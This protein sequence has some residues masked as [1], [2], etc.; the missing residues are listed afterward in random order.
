[1]C[2]NA[3]NKDTQKCPAGYYCP[4]GSGDKTKLEC[5][6]GF[7]CKEEFTFINEFIEMTVTVLYQKF[8]SFYSNLDSNVNDVTLE[9]Q[10]GSNEYLKS[11]QRL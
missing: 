6:A 11:C 1:L 10:F 7:F 4:P 9:E 2:P 3:E 8:L 5:P